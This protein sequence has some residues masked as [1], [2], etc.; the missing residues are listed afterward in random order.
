MTALR[1][2]SIFNLRSEPRVRLKETK[3][4]GKP[5]FERAEISIAKSSWWPDYARLHEQGVLT[6]CGTWTKNNGPRV[7][8]VKH[9]TIKWS[10]QGESNIPAGPVLET[11]IASDPEQGNE[12]FEARSVRTLQSGNGHEV[13]SLRTYTEEQVSDFLQVSL[14]QL[15]KWRMKRNQGTRQGPPFKKFGRLVRYPEEGLQG[16]HQWLNFSEACSPTRRIGLQAL[17][18]SCTEVVRIEAGSSKVH[19]I[20]DASVT[21]TLSVSENAIGERK[22]TR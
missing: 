10:S 17:T 4:F 22:S 20:S 16:L 18:R 8:G 15:R 1:R 21:L 19:L 7:F 2:R 3:L 11:R 13:P 5:T 14:S 12:G 6:T 9:E